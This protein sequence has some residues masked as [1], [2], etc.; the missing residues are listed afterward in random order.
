MFSE[1]WNLLDSVKEVLNEILKHDLSVAHF[2]LVFKVA[3][4]SRSIDAICEMQ[5]SEV[6]GDYCP[7]LRMVFEVVTSAWFSPPELD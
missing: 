2:D 4:I 1:A 7:I 3:D 5:F 6:G